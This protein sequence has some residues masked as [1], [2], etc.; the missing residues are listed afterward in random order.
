MMSNIYKRIGE[1]LEGNGIINSVLAYDNDEEVVLIGAGFTRTGSVEVD[2]EIADVY[3]LVKKRKV[4][5][6]D[7]VHTLKDLKKLRDKI[8]MSSTIDK[9]YLQRWNTKY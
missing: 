4:V 2:G 8:G 5:F 6:V 1:V 9:P 7:D 3:T